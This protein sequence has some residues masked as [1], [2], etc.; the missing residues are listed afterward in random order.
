MDKEVA[1]FEIEKKKRLTALDGTSNDEEAQPD[2]SQTDQEPPQP[3]VTE[4][5]QDDPEKATNVDSADSEP[6]SKPADPD[7]DSANGVERSETTAAKE[8]QGEA[9]AKTNGDVV[10]SEEKQKEQEEAEDDGDHIV[11]GDEDN[12]IY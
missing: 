10:I 11:E 4:A 8:S 5:A 12:V 9:D 7:G 2:R 3:V 6:T 1:E